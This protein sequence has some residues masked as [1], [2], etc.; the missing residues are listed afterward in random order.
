MGELQ[1]P[2]FNYRLK[3]VRRQF[4]AVYPVH[5]W[6]MRIVI[7]SDIHGNWEALSALPRE[8]DERWVLGDLVNYGPNPAEVLPF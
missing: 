7:I 5:G 4:H 3:L 2:R 6:A 8:Y 1:H